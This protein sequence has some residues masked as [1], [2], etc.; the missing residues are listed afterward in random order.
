MTRARH[1]GDPRQPA[2]AAFSTCRCSRVPRGAPPHEAALHAR[3]LPRG[4]RP[5]PRAAVPGMNFSTDI[6]VGFPGE[7]EDDFEADAQPDA[8]RSASDRSSRSS[9]RRGRELRPEARS[10][11]VED[12]VAADGSTALRRSGADREGVAPDLRRPDRARAGRGGQ[13]QD[14]AVL[15][16]KSE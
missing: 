4:R 11:P 5:H 9:I 7:T 14:P 10:L 13:Q 15:S 8:K 12:A 16:G 2:S 3:A 1:R 6:I